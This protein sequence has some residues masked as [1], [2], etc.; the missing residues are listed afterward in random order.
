MGNVGLARAS[1]VQDNDVIT[2]TMIAVS[3]DQMEVQRQARND[4]Q[5]EEKRRAEQRWKL[6]E[7]KR[8]CEERA[9]A[10]E[11][12][13]AWVARE[14]NVQLKKQE[15]AEHVGSEAIYRRVNSKLANL[16][17]DLFFYHE[18][19]R[20]YGWRNVYLKNAG[21]IDNSM[22]DQKMQCLITQMFDDVLE[23]DCSSLRLVE[24]SSDSPQPPSYFWASSYMFLP[25][26]LD[27][28]VTTQADVKFF[29]PSEVSRW[30]S[31][32]HP[33]PCQC[34]WCGYCSRKLKEMLD[35]MP[36]VG[37]LA[38]LAL[39]YWDL[40]AGESLGLTAG[41]ISL[42]ELGI[43]KVLEYELPQDCLPLTLRLRMKTGPEPRALSGRGQELVRRLRREIMEVQEARG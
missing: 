34:Q 9:A 17:V 40:Q 33:E 39:G 16:E 23:T 35:Y 41:P 42:T 20:L 6:R 31:R 12:R 36:T 30:L 1:A 11:Y 5:A 15:Q 38:E 37:P 13:K 29:L 21:Y 18:Q 43:K 7:G 32:L 25:G 27:P 24:D 14:K 22:Y 4:R 26:I 3:P 19:L 10:M 8:V 28:S 2:Q